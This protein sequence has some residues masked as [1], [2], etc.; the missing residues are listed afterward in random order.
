[1]LRSAVGSLVAIQGTALIENLSPVSA[2]VLGLLA[3]ATGASLMAGF[4]TPIAAS[5]VALDA[6]TAWLYVNPAN[7][8]P[9]KLWMAFFL[10][11]AVCLVLLGPGAFSLDARL[12]GFREIIIPRSP[13][14]E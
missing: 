8:F 9:S 2:W 1:M 7:L 11:V 10:A 5:L 13:T 6:V 3:I 14:N 4:L 12:F